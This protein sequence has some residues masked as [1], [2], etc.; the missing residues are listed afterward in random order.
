MNLYVG[1][2]YGELT[3]EFNVSLTG[4][5]VRT[6]DFFYNGKKPSNI[7]SFSNHLFFFLYISDA[8]GPRGCQ[9][10]EVDRLQDAHQP[11]IIFLCIYLISLCLNLYRL[12]V[13]TT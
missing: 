10:P 4:A 7:Y 13:H 1:Q 12:K 11:G 9:E 8:Q 3:G 2:W 6:G 5:P